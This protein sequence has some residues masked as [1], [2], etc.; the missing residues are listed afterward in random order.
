MLNWDELFKV[1]L[2]KFGLNGVHMEVNKNPKKV[3]IWVDQEFIMSSGD[4]YFIKNNEEERLHRVFE[5]D[6]TN[7][8]PPLGRCKVKYQVP[9]NL[10]K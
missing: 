10:R 7:H 3:E 2:M 4:N 1:I 9:C 5:D 6:V 8:R